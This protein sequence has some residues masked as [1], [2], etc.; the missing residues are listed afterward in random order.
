MAKDFLVVHGAAVSCNKGSTPTTLVVAASKATAEGK[1]VAVVSDKTFAGTFGTC[2]LLG[3]GPCVPATP[4]NWSPGCTKERVNGAFCVKKSDHLS[5]TVDPSGNSISI[6]S[7][8]Q[9]KAQGE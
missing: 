9:S 5:C 1:N 7:A 3:P 2:S 4:G 6:T 8:G